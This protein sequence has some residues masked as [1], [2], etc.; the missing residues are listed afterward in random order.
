[1]VLHD[2]PANEVV[3]VEQARVATSGWILELPAGRV[4]PNEDP[5]AT[6][7]REAEEETGAAPATVQRIS[8]FYLSPGG[9]SERL[10]LFYCPFSDGLTVHEYAGLAQDSE[11]IRVHRIPLPRALEMIE[12]GEIADAKTMIGLYWLARQA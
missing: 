12:T 4:E 11:D 10:H 9:C 3:F 7:G 1:L 8:R 2:V 5:A 6:A